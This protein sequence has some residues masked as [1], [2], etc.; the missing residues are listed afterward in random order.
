MPTG[1]TYIIADGISFKNFV[2][3]C[4]RNF[5]ALVTMRDDSLDVEVPDEILPS[6]YHKKEMEKIRIKL[7]NAKKMDLDT[8][9]ECASKEFLDA[10]ISHSKSFLKTV[11]LRQKYIE[12]LS[13][14]NSWIPPTKDHENLKEFMIDQ[15][16]T[17]IEFDCSAKFI[18]RLQSE[19]I[20]P[21]ENLIKKTGN[22][23]LS[24]HIA[25]LENNLE[26]HTK[27]YLEEVERCKERTEWIQALK[28]SLKEDENGT[29]KVP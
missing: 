10:V 12:M 2:L 26:Y 15:I 6:D 23:W 22:E 20:N 4:A 28:Q 27:E 9:E 17:S 24:N 3:R 11:E 13:K 16:T 19:I 21:K 14:V 29:T 18:G 5:G 1:Y 7:E 25:E 8:A